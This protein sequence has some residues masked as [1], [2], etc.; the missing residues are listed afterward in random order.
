[1]AGA[2]FHGGADLDGVQFIGE[3]DLHGTKFHGHVWLVTAQFSQGT[4]LTGEIVTASGAALPSRWT[5]RG[6]KDGRGEVVPAESPE[7]Q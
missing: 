5:V 6:L 2:Q 3:A 1:M 7:Q 4:G